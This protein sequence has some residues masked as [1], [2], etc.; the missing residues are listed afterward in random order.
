MT[1]EQARALKKGTW[2]YHKTLLT[3]SKVKTPYRAKVTSV[4]MW[5]T[6]PNDVKIGLKAGLYDYFTAG[7]GSVYAD[8]TIEE[9]N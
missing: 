2:I 7:S 8:S 1:L 6:R 9:W 4:L 3:K 5:K